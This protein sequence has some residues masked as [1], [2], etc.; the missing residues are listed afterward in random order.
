MKTNKIALLS[1]TPVLRAV[2]YALVGIAGVVGII[3]GMADPGTVGTWVDHVPSIAA[4]VASVLAL[5]NIHPAMALT[6]TKVV[7]TDESD[8]LTDISEPV[9][10]VSDAITD[11]TE[12]YRLQLLEGKND[13]AETH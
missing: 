12:A 3:T 11:P 6:D 5:A 8:A 7:L 2:I 13:V 4:T 1:T 10:D 9:T